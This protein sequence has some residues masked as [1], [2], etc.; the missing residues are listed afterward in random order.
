MQLKNIKV[1]KLK[2]S[3][4]IAL[5]L[6]F[7]SPQLQAQTVTVVVNDTI[8]ICLGTTVTIDLLAND[9]DV[10]PGEVLETDIIVDP[11]SLLISYEDD[12]LPEG[13]YDVIIDPAF[14]GADFLIY[15]VCG[16]DGL[17]ATGELVILVGNC[18]WPGDGNLDSI[19]NNFDL[20][21]FGVYYGLTGPDRDDVDG[22]W[23]EAFADPWVI[24]GGVTLSSNPKNSDFNGDGVVDGNDTI[25]ML[26][27]Y[28]DLRGTYVPVAYVG[29]PDDP[30]LSIAF[31]SD[32]ILAGSKVVIPINFGT[33]ILPASN[34]YGVAFDI[35][36]DK[37]LINADSIKATFNSGWLGTPGD[38]IISI[39][40][41]DTLNGILSV[42]VTRINQINR[43]GYNHFGELSFVME[44]NI[45]GKTAE[46]ITATLNFCIELPQVINKNGTAIPVQ[47]ACDSAVAIQFTN[48][49]IEEKN[50]LIV[51]FPNP[52]DGTLT[53]ALPNYFTGKCL[54]INALGQ[55]VIAQS[56][57]SNAI[58]L[59]TTTIAS[60]N[61]V[62]QLISTSETLYK[63]I[64]IQH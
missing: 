33:A 4:L 8:R 24:P 27:N 64:I 51:T 18:V 6:Y 30:E 20:L 28:G 48:S 42:A 54:L 19:C 58:T 49:I 47:I 23:D 60:G 43:T 52:V 1:I 46:L 22:D 13:T 61:Y 50:N 2:A 55:V 37:T 38:D 16:E 7:A 41:N 32:T 14:V 11:T 26:S 45:A 40:N 17:C 10:D 12:D 9:T 15:E 44:D 57:N 34:I 35:I 25:I 21:P 31:L 39:Q 56:I 62:V 29:G 5:L 53:I 3:A 36:Y 63:Q 59:N